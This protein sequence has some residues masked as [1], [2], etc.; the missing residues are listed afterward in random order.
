MTRVLVACLVIA[1]GS[2]AR[3][4][5]KPEPLTG[6]VSLDGKPLV[7]GTVTFVAKDGK[8]A[9]VPLA[10]DGTYSAALDP[11]EYRVAIKGP[12]PKKGEVPP[13][14]VPAKYG[15]PATSGLVI[16]ATGKNQVHDIELKSK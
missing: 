11:G 14:L 16:V 8:A 7:A 2:A 6:K 15:D 1:L 9:T 10:A 5:A 4:E 3:A 12:E 13:V